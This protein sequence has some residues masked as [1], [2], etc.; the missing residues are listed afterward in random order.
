M[1]ILQQ[2]VSSPLDVLT[3]EERRSF[4]DWHGGDYYSVR[5]EA[6]IL[7]LCS[8]VQKAEAQVAAFRDIIETIRRI[9]GKPRQDHACVKCDPQAELPTHWQG[10]RCWYHMDLDTAGSALVTERDSAKSHWD[11]V[12]SLFP[13]GLDVLDS[14]RSLLR[15]IGSSPAQ[16][17]L[18]LAVLRKLLHLVWHA[19]DDSEEN[20]QTG[21]VT[22]TLSK[23]EAA[24]L[25]A[26]IPEEHP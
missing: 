13:A 26:L 9:E 25:S 19:F 22:F 16:K 2:E 1:T 12:C 7:S 11:E 24:K 8:R 10:F 23:T 14:I 6:I 3:D 15:S 17:D 4:S 21:E 20:A 5:A 18:E